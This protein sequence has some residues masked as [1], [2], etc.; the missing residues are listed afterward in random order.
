MARPRKEPSLAQ[1]IR[2]SPELDAPARRH[3]LAV[4]PHLT[5]EDR[6]RLREILSSTADAG[7]AP[8]TP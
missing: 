2:R 1:L 5:D 4:L 8:R 3:W 7:D 6:Q